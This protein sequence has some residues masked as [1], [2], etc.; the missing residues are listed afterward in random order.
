MKG[1]VKMAAVLA[2][3]IVAIGA[4]SVSADTAY[5][6]TDGNWSDSADT[7]WYTENPDQTSYT[8]STAEELAGLAKLVNGTDTTEGIGFVGVTI[9]LTADINLSGKE[10][11]PIGDGARSDSTYTGD[12]F[13]GTF[14]GGNCTIT[15]LTITDS[16]NEDYALGLFGVIDGGTV[17]GLTMLDVS[18]TDDTSEIAGA[19]S[20]RKMP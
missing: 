7:D 10:W 12:P 20:A 14:V 13:K 6:A 18:I 17:E 8:I 11:T 2:V 16:S 19:L 1:I 3:M 9:T 5:A 15:G 4:V